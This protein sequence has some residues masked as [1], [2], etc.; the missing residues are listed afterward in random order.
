[1]AGAFDHALYA[2]LQR[3]PGQRAQGDHFVPLGG[4]ARVASRAGAQAVPEGK[5]DVIPAG[6]AEQTVK[7][8]EQGVFPVVFKHPAG[9]NA[10]PARDDAHGASAFGRPFRPAPGDAAV[11]GHEVHALFGLLFHFREQTFRLHVSRVST[12]IKVVL[13]HAIQGHGS[14]RGGAARAGWRQDR[15]QW[16]DPSRYR[17]RPRERP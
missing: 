16:T 2:C 5:G 8:R 11:Q 14:Q 9:Q 15:P 7:I 13:R 17:L 6:N 1:M 3:A 4:I 10:A 12:A